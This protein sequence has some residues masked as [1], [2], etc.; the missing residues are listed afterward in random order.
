MHR[1]FSQ[2][3]RLAR[4]RSSSLALHR[5][6]RQWPNVPM[7]LASSANANDASANIIWD[8]PLQPISRSKSTA[9]SATYDQTVESFPSIVIGPNGSIIP[10]GSFA[11]AQAEVR[12]KRG[13]V[14]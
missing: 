1:S 10:Q 7:L 11:E 2:L 4:G 12:L 14:G 8:Q 3:C 13:L 5:S 9:A 6:R